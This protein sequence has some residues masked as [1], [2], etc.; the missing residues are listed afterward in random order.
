MHKGRGDDNLTGSW[1]AGQPQKNAAA[2]PIRYCAVAMELAAYLDGQYV[3]MRILTDT[4]KTISVV[5][6]KDSI[7]TV[8]R[9][10]ERL[11]QGCPEI[12]TWKPAYTIRARH[13]NGHGSYASALTER[14]HRSPLLARPMLVE[15]AQ[16][17][18]APLYK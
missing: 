15:T 2:E 4:G 17:I 8:Q 7:F 3:E 5:C 9:Q 16:A 11:G 12:A 13:D 18:P 6:E 10:I 14:R 1:G